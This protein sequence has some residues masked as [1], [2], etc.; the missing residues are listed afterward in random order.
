MYVCGLCQR[1][2]IHQRSFWEW[3]RHQWLAANSQM[4]VFK[5]LPDRVWNASQDHLAGKIGSNWQVTNPEDSMV[6]S[7]KHTDTVI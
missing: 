2:G 1:L 5:I 4:T 6:S 3:S 7:L